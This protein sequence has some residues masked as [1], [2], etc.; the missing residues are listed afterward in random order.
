VR[1]F[2]G[3]SSCYWLI[4]HWVAMAIKIKMNPLR[5]HFQLVAVQHA[6]PADR[7]AHEIAPISPIMCCAR[8]G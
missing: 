6:H 1:A 8:G 4:T 7:F 3:L 5:R 2:C